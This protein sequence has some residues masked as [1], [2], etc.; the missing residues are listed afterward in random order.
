MFE[1]AAIVAAMCATSQD[2][3]NKGQARQKLMQKIEHLVRWNLRFIQGFFDEIMS[4]KMWRMEWVNYIE[5][6]A[7]NLLMLSNQ[8]P[9]PTIEE[10]F[11]DTPQGLKGL[12]Q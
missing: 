4:K 12:Y 1:L 8:F 6:Y 2:N 10:Y 3:K 9:A 11:I 7:T 5:A